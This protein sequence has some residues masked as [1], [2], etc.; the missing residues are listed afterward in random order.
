MSNHH[1]LDSHS[2]SAVDLCEGRISSCEIH[3]EEERL[4]TDGQHR[5]R[6]VHG[7]ICHRCYTVASLHT[8]RPQCQLDRVRAIG[9]AN[10]MSRTKIFG[11]GGFEPFHL[12]SKHQP[13]AENHTIY[14]GPDCVFISTNVRRQIID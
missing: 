8:H 6:S 3:I 14:R 12:W 1:C 13:T 7:G 10:A 4:R 9:K 11:K 5:R 2:D